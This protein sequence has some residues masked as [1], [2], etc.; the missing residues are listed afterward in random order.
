MHLRLIACL[1]LPL[2]AGCSMLSDLGSNACTAVD[3]QSLA[4]SPNGLDAKIYG[5]PVALTAP[6][7]SP[8]TIDNAAGE[9]RSLAD[10]SYAD[11]Q[12]ARTADASTMQGQVLAAQN[13]AT[14]AQ[15]LTLAAQLGAATNDA[16]VNRAV[17]TARRAHEA[18]SAQ[19]AATPLRAAQTRAPTMAATS[20]TTASASDRDSLLSAGK[21]RYP[22]GYAP[23]FGPGM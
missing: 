20:P 13:Q 6:P 22:S 11:C 21:G 3:R 12:T 1:G 16:E 17:A 5:I 7:I 4:V 9:L 23:A 15:L 10:Q 14:R 8:I 2:V 18:A 19:R